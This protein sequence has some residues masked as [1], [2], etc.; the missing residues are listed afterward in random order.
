MYGRNRGVG[1]LCRVLPCVVAQVGAQDDVLNDGLRFVVRRFLGSG[2]N[3]MALTL[4]IRDLAMTQ[5]YV[6]E[7]R[8]GDN[9]DNED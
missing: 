4:H 3:R 5:C 2:A 7:G 1:S 6:L 9:E 8:R